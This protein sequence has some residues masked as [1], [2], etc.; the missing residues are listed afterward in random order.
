MLDYGT[1]FI[2]TE[3]AREAYLRLNLKEDSDLDDWKR[4]IE[5]LKY[6]FYGRFLNQIEKLIDYP[7]YNREVVKKN[8]FA[9]MA[10]MCLLIDTFMQFKNGYPQS[11][12][13]SII[14]QK[15]YTDFLRDSLHFGPDEADRFYEDIRCGILHSA[16]TKNGSCLVP[17]DRVFSIDF[18]NNIDYIGYSGEN[19]TIFT[20]SVP[21]MYNAL[22]R[23]FNNYCEELRES[24]GTRRKNFVTKMNDV[25]RKNDRILEEFELWNKICQNKGKPFRTSKGNSFSYDILGSKRT[26]VV[27][28]VFDTN[29]HIPFS[30]IKSFLNYHEKKAQRHFNNWFYIESI[31]KG[32]YPEIDSFIR[33]HVA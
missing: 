4:A 13:G 25:T 28:R 9:A 8:G 30:D 29:I 1:I 24:I 33:N 7:T 20:V 27:K 10:L 17:E 23:Y 14:N 26:L 16:E 5:I 22:N 18:G 3:D 31:L 21:G 11:Y 12:L 19:K 32:F 15:E 6:R 2:S